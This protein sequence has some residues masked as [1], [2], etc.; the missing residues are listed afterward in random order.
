MKFRLSIAVTLLFLVTALWAYNSRVLGQW[1]DG[2]WYP[3]TIV[4]ENEG[5]FQVSFDDGDTAELDGLKIKEIDWK[6][7]SSIECNWKD[8]GAYYPGKI[9]K[10]SGDSIHMSYDDGDQEDTSI[11]KCRSR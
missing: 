7:G 10:K 4:G 5:V 8:G 6:V 2:Y 1:S 11:S 9:T 3:A